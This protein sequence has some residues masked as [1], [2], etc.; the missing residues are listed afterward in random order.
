MRL[1][2]FNILHGRSPVDDKVVVGRFE[3]AVKDL[4]ADVLAL[5][6]VDRNQPRSA[7]ADLTDVAAEAMGP[8]EHRFVAALS[9]SP[10][11]TWMA[12]TGEEQPDAAAYGIALLTRYPV[13]S[14]EVIRLPPVPTQVPMR[15]RG[16]LRPV[17]VR[18][19]PR[20]AVAAVLD[21]R[22][23]PMTVVNTHLSFIRWWNRHQ[24]RVLMRALE[25]APAPL[26]LMGDLN[27][28]PPAATKLTGLRPL[29]WGPTFPADGP[30]EQI[31]HILACDTMTLKGP[32][33]THRFELSDHLALSVDLDRPS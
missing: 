6:E 1:V 4:D 12:A 31:D 10:G 26:V 5:Q 3:R 20:V 32:S 8:T 25:T 18:D 27:M 23:G 13:H 19:E 21:T 30:R 29:A 33:R 16:R 14:W 24:L 7:H 22:R 2:T 15:F 9:G 28:E 17:L 11:A